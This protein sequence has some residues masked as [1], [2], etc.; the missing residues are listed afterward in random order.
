MTPA[1]TKVAIVKELESRGVSFNPKDNKDALSVR[2]TA[3]NYRP[4]QMT[5]PE[6]YKLKVSVLKEILEI[7]GKP[8]KGLTRKDKLID[9]LIQMN[10]E[11]S[12]KEAAVKA[13]NTEKLQRI[14]PDIMN[15]VKTYLT[16]PERMKAAIAFK[17]IP[18]MEEAAQIGIPTRLTIV[19]GNTYNLEGHRPLKDFLPQQLHTNNE[20]VLENDY[21]S[22]N[23]TFGMSYEEMYEIRIKI[24][25]KVQATAAVSAKCYI[26]LTEKQFNNRSEHPEK[27]DIYNFRYTIEA[28]NPMN[29][30]IDSYQNDMTYV[31]IG[32]LWIKQY[33]SYAF[34]ESMKDRN[35]LP[36]IFFY[37]RTGAIPPNHYGK[38]ISLFTRKLKKC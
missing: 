28:V 36:R 38:Y 15:V 6:L 18:M 1:L 17:D 5:R 20:W 24:T 35:A 34:S 10:P 7:H 4:E 3:S 29:L 9:A 16:E 14:P 25:P 12:Q 37:D 26:H 30:N 21:V 2:L 22:V 32:F 33:M 8:T 11:A 13:E 23:Y 27:H 19:N 31:C